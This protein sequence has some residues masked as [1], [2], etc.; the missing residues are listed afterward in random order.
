[1]IISCSDD[2]TVKMYDLNSNKCIKQFKSKHLILIFIGQGHE[3]K[4]TSSS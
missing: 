3:I 4:S 2:F 1:M